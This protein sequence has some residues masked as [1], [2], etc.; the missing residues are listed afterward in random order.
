LRNEGQVGK[1]DRR[2]AAAKVARVREWLKQDTWNPRFRRRI[3]PRPLNE[4]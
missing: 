2:E 3:E 4:L 1:L